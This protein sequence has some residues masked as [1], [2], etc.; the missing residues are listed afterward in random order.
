MNHSE[1]TSMTKVV[2]AST[3]GTILEWYD[4]GVYGIAAALVFNELFFPKTLPWVGTLLSFATFG[5]GFLARPVGGIVFGYIGDRFGR[6]PAMMGTILVMGVASALIGVLPTYGAVGV[7]APILLVVLRLIQGFG[8]G[9]EYAG[10]LVY[11]VESASKYRG[12]FGSFPSVAVPA[13]IILYSGVFSVI[14]TLPK[15]DL[16][17][18]GWRIP[19]LLS[20]LTVG[21]GLYIRASLIETL[22]PSLADAQAPRNPVREV[23]V[24][25]PKQ[26][27]LTMLVQFQGVHTYTIQ[28]FILA[29]LSGSL[30]ISKSFGSAALMI[31]A[32]IGMGILLLAGW[33]GDKTSLKSVALA[34]ALFSGLFAFPMFA[35]LHTRTPAAIILALVL[36]LGGAY[37]MWGP[38]SALLPQLFPPDDRYTGVA[39]GR[40]LGNA[41]ISGSAPVVATLL[42][43]F[44]QGSIWPVAGYL[45]VSSA[46]V[47]FSIAFL[48]KRGQGMDVT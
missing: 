47:F 42:T 20:V 41:I 44:A 28:T 31:A 6:K 9:A 21:V 39:V 48:V 12:F 2:A 30:G 13:S 1:Q 35:L 34:G 38:T 32:V 27:L 19:F 5:V 29:Y 22:Q 33:L 17:T 24:K 46:I 37:V 18:W 45:V 10:A 11:T 26:L 14:S 8:A 40:E 16:L 15:A 36:G 43:H 4:F 7:W 25:H 23:F 3:I